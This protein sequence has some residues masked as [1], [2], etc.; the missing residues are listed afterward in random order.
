MKGELHLPFPLLADA[1]EQVVKRY[2][3]L[4]PKGHGDADIARPAVL[5][6]DGQGVIRWAMFTDNFRVRARPEAL[7]QAAKRL[8]ATGADHLPGSPSR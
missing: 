3:L 4:H 7:L 5:L 8:P 1:D 6:L 2:G